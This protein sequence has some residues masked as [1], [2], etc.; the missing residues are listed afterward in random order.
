MMG[1]HKSV[2]VASLPKCD[3]CGN[4]TLAHYDCKTVFGPWANL[5]DA[6]FSEYG[7]GLGLGYGQELVLTD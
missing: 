4:S 1:D 2:K 7:I 6:H 3:A 5:C